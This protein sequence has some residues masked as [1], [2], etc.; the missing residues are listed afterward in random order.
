MTM[1]FIIKLLLSMN[2]II[3]KN[4]DAI[5]IIINHLTEYSHI[6]F[7]KKKYIAKQFCRFTEA[8]PLK[9]KRIRILTVKVI[10]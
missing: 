8:K 4:Y 6:I 1:N 7:F 5:L 9:I 10:T 3:K 2:L